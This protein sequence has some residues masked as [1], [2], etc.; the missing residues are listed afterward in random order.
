MCDLN[1]WSITVDILISWSSH[2]TWH[3]SFLGFTWL[4]TNQLHRETSEMRRDFTW[5]LLNAFWCQVNA[6]WN[7]FS[8]ALFAITFSDVITL[9]WDEIFTVGT[10]SQKL[11]FLLP[12]KNSLYFSIGFILYLFLFNGVGLGWIIR[13]YESCLSSWIKLGY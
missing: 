7:E 4:N 9:V 3:L 5:H 12:W 11:Q 2:F 1:Q 13:D 6:F 10:L 8:S